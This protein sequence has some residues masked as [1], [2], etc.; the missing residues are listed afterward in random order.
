MKKILVL[1]PH[2]DDETLGCGG[3]LLKHQNSKD[4]IFCIFLTNLKKNHKM[5]KKKIE[6]IKRVSKAYR[7]DDYFIGKFNPSTLEDIP[8][9][10]IISYLQKIINKIKP[11][12][13]LIP[14]PYDAHHDHRISF[15]CMTVFFKSFRYSFIK[16][17]W[18]YETLSETNFTENYTKQFF[19]PNT[20]V[21]ITDFYQK[22]IKIFS[23]YAS[24]YDL[25]PH[26]RSF[27]A[28]KSLAVLRGSYSNVKYAEAFQIIK[29]IL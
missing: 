21:D 13:L 16:E 5:Y 10:D 17:V 7:F 11:D 6:E 25:S 1:A 26:P 3:T 8:K 23:N 15:E 28:I 18:M 29:N 27:E 24:E 14:F 22:K 9:Q 4:K 12:K 19:Q 20:W 2:P